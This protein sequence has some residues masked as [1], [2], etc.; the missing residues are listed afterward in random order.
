[1]F[2]D[3]QKALRS[4]Q[5]VERELGR[6]FKNYNIN[7]RRKDRFF[8]FPDTCYIIPKTSIT[9][10]E[11]KIKAEIVLPGLHLNDIKLKISQDLIEL[12]TSKASQEPFKSYYAMIPMP[13]GIFMKSMKKIYR[14]G[15]LTLQ[16]D[17]YMPRKLIDEIEELE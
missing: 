10:T 1:M 11:T 6:V 8:E 16:F 12:T 7:G 3:L 14:K 5:K 9:E 13:S 4:M 17:K 15:V 2:N